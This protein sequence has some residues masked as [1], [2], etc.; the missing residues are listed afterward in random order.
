M[1][2]LA[3]RW[4]STEHGKHNLLNP[5]D[6]IFHQLAAGCREHFLGPALVGAQTSRHKPTDLICYDM[7]LS[8]WSSFEKMGL[9][10]R[11]ALKAVKRQQSHAVDLKEV[12]LQ[13]L[14]PCV[15]TIRS[16]MWRLYTCI[17]IYTRNIHCVESCLESRALEGLCSHEEMVDLSA[18]VF[19][20][21][22]MLICLL[23]CN[24]YHNANCQ[25]TWVI[26]EH[27]WEE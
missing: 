11:M 14:C 27:R 8:A 10:H 4:I 9:K 15:A 3:Q 2:H 6:V 16:G 21:W 19:R 20:Q 22:L 18:E 25:E 17:Y 12:W 23:S 5:F 7:L 26:R 1:I 13:V 24:F